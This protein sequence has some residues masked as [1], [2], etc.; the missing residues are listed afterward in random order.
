M[1]KYFTFSGSVKR[2]EYWGTMVAIT[3]IAILAIMMAIGMMVSV[4][5]SVV[6]TGFVLMLAAIVVDLW[7]SLAVAAKR[8]RDI[9][10]HPMWGLTIYAP[11][12]GLVAALVIG[13]VPSDEFKQ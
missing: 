6:V 10:V 13:I 5:P 11:Y 8:C 3:V 9:G 2:A 12:V 1:E 7:V 4:T